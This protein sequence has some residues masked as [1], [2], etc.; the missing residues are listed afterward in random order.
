MSLIT[1]DMGFVLPTEGESGAGNA[2]NANFQDIESGRTHAAYL[3][4]AMSEAHVGY[5]AS[6][7]QA[8][9]AQA[10]TESTAHFAGFLETDG[11]LGEQ[12]RF[13]SNGKIQNT[14]WNFADIGEV[15]YLSATEAGGVTQSQPGDPNLTVEL[16]IAYTSNII[17]IMPAAYLHATPGTQ[18]VFKTITGDSG[19]TTADAVDD[20][21]EIEG[22]SNVETTV[23]PKKVSIAIAATP[24]GLTIDGGTA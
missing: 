11:A 14:D 3:G 12:K 10:N 17:W 2:I 24:T 15:V 5:I 8:Y 21:L 20:T 13:R 1:T 4:E 6:D 22:G 18:S 19:S 23:T 16:G 7:G 9:K